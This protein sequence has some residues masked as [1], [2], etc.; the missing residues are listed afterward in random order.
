M[1]EARALHVVVSSNHP[2]ADVQV[3]EAIARVMSRYAVD[4]TPEVKV[5]VPY[6]GVE[7][8]YVAR[9]AMS[10]AS[11]LRAARAGN[12]LSPN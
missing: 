7:V 1:V 10:L 6:D 12:H 3:A 5:N 8:P 2:A 4:L 11:Q 9:P